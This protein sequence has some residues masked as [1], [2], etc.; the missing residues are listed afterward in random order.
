[1]T[2]VLLV[3]DSKFMAKNMKK[4]L[5]ALSFDVVGIGHDG[6][7]GVDRFREL[8]PD[9]MLLDVTMPNMDGL[10]CLM[11]VRKEHPDARVIM[12]SAIKDEDLIQQCFE[13]GA[14]E[15]LTKPIRF[16]D[17]NDCDRLQNAIDKAMSLAN[18]G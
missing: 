13:A 8:K 5:E 11:E 3:D 7:E 16:N 15:Y 6:I 2:T 1:M 17:P 14:S 12:L 10:S 4:G 18:E 9:V